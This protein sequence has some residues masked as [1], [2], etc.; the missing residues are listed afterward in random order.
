[1]DNKI[2][3]KAKRVGVAVYIS[4]PLTLYVPATCINDP[5]ELQRQ[6]ELAFDRWLSCNPQG[7]GEA[8]VAQLSEVYPIKVL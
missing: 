4:T 3:P 8:I 6:S 2:A 5:K 7:V 1:M